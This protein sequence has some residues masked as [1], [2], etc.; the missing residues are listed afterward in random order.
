MALPSVPMVSNAITSISIRVTRPFKPIR[1][2][3]PRSNR[4]S[5]LLIVFHER[6]ADAAL[7]HLR[8]KGHGFD[9]YGLPDQLQTRAGAGYALLHRNAD[10]DRKYNDFLDHDWIV[11][12]S[13]Q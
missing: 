4:F 5:R 7:F 6:A 1:L 12:E 13:D 2:L 10:A 8:T 9:Y 11:V 3:A